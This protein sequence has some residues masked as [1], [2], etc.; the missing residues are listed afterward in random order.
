MLR[1]N[2]A[3]LCVD[4]FGDRSDP[5]ILLIGGAGGSMNWWVSAFCERLAAGPRY[6]IRYDLR[7]T[8]QSQT[9][10]PGAPSY[11]F[12]DL[13]RD[14]AGLIEEL[15]VAPAH[16]LGI[17]MGGAV[18]MTLALDRPELVSTLTLLSTS[19]GGPGPD[20]GLPA[21]DPQL[22]ES[23]A[24]PPPDPDWSDRDAV[25]AYGLAADRLFAGSLP[26]DE[27]A[28][29]E[30]LGRIYDRTRDNEAAAKNHWLLQGG[31]PVRPRLG[32]I[33][34]PTLVLH[35]TE[36]RLFP[37]GHGEALAAEIPGARLALMEHVGHE[38]PPPAVWD[39]VVPDV[40]Q[41]TTWAQRDE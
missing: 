23:F 16:V 22:A 15:D 36:D 26:Y 9:D 5:S 1:V 37:L 2:G 17:S 7:D 31:E 35:G 3:V 20:N 33:A 13:A 39:A 27:S 29:R 38:V 30:L 18:A 32:E 19:T 34:M 25:I 8:G 14:A 11:E 40:L 28:K 12:P 24:S 41:H 21:M 6:V 4:T 10:P